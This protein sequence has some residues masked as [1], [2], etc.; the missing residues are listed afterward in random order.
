[1]QIG[2]IFNSSFNYRWIRMINTAKEAH[3]VGKLNGY[4]ES[5]TYI[6]ELIYFY[7]Q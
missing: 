7:Q 1:M 5:M 4:K 2:G 6:K 3:H